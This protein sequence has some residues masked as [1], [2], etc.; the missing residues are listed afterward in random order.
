VH[1]LGARR[2]ELRDGRREADGWVTDEFLTR[3]GPGALAALLAQNGWPE[4]LPGE[5]WWQLAMIRGPADGHRE[6]LPPRAVEEPPAAVAWDEAGVM[7]L[8]PAAGRADA[9][10]AGLAV[11]R[12]QMQPC[13]HGRA[14]AWPY[15]LDRGLW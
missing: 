13:G 11:Y 2:W 3:A 5:P 1:N 6:Y 8:L 9:A 15:L 14:C 12:L 10:E 4:L 7:R